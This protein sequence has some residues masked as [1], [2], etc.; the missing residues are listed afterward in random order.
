MFLVT[1]ISLYKAGPRDEAS[2]QSFSSV[3][4]CGLPIFVRWALINCKITS[5]DKEAGFSDKS[6]LDEAAR[7]VST[8]GV[9]LGMIGVGVGEAA[10]NFFTSCLIF[11]VTDE[12]EADWV[13][14]C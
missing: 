1:N 13:A 4:K 14:S 3:I 5:V 12:I 6:V 7:T 8:G 9:S 2:V 11:W 10:A